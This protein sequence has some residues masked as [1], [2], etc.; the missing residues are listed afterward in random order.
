MIIFFSLNRSWMGSLLQHNQWIK[1]SNHIDFL[2]NYPLKQ[3]LSFDESQYSKRI[4]RIE[5]SSPKIL[6]RLDLPME[7]QSQKVHNTL[8]QTWKRLYL[9]IKP[10]EP[11]KHYGITCVHTALRIPINVKKFLKSRGSGPPITLNHTHE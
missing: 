7:S 10:Q 3:N 6:E 8:M 11:P 4:F 2:H 1:S 9:K 5:N